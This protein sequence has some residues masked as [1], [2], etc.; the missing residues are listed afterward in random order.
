MTPEE[1]SASITR[2]YDSLTE[3]ERAEILSWAEFAET[4][5]SLEDTN[6]V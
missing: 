2:Y 5:F 3:A 1:I 4:Q 6:E